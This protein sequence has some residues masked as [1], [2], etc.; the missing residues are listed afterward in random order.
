MSDQARQAE[1]TEREDERTRRRD[2]RFA[3]DQKLGAFVT[4]KWLVGALVMLVMSMGGYIFKGIDKGAD[5]QAATIA[6][7]QSDTAKHE[8]EIATMKAVLQLNYN[9]VIR[10][11]DNIE[12]RLDNLGA[13]PT[14]PPLSPLPLKRH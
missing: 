8:V 12:R 14:L 6:T 7:L 9:E 4:N 13:L 11:L 2:S 3:G 10:R 1:L 5:V